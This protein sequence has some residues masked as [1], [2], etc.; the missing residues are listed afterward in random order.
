[1]SQYT[2]KYVISGHFFLLCNHTGHN[3]RYGTQMVEKRKMEGKKLPIFH[4]KQ[5]FE[6]VLHSQLL[7]LV[8]STL[9][10]QDTRY[11]CSVDLDDYSLS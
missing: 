10:N 11:K 6:E 3:L 8:S 5:M 9:Q 1:M 2:C 4:G 7:S